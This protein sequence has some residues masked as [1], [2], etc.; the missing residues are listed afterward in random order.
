MPCSFSSGNL[1]RGNFLSTQ[2]NDA[3]GN[4][5][6]GRS[7]LQ[8]TPNGTTSVF[9]T[10]DPNNIIIQTNC[11]ADGVGLTMALVVLKAGY[12]LV[13]STP[14]PIGGTVAGP[15]CIILLDALVSNIDLR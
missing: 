3:H 10:I 15:G 12:V 13:G 7:I 9:S 5:G 6:Q 2:W 14:V 4:P 11:G 8:V 1:I